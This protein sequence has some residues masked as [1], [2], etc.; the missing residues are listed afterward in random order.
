MAVNLDNHCTFAGHRV[1]D[2]PTGDTCQ[3]AEDQVGTDGLGIEL[4]QLDRS[5][6]YRWALEDAA[7]ALCHL[8]KPHRRS[9][10]Y[11][12]VLYMLAL[13]QLLQLTVF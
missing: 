10:H 1:V 6:P 11:Q 3:T 12:L 5:Y 8:D 13:L 9:V 2:R 7:T 4:R